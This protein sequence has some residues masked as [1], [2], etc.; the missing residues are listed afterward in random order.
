M[1]RPSPRQPG[2]RIASTLQHKVTGYLC[3]TDVDSIAEA[4][5]TV[6]RSRV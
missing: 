6:L 5:E 3:G 2:R 1:R 4:I